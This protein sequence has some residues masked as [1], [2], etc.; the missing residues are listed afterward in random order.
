MSETL[1][2]RIEI[3]DL[4]AKL[5]RLLDEQRFDDLHTVY[6]RDIEALSPRG[7]LRGLE[8]LTSSMNEHKVDGELHQHVHGDVLVHLD[9]DRAE[10]TANQLVFFYRAGDP[11]HREAGLRSAATAVRT[12]QG[13]RFSRMHIQ[14]LWL[15]KH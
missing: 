10:T 6:H 11:P 15:R 3:A 14:L 1:T 12:P 8:E 2:D 5:S 13:W 7:E 4:F 9:G